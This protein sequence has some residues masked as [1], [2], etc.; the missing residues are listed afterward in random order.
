MLLLHLVAVAPWYLT[1]NFHPTTY[2]GIDPT[3]AQKAFVYAALDRDLNLMALADVEMDDLMAFVV[4][5]KSVLIAINSPLSLN[6]GLLKEKIK[7]AADGRRQIR[8]AEFRLAEH[9][10]RDCGI[11]VYGTPGNRS[12]CPAWMGAG[13]E[14]LRRIKEAGFDKYPHEKASQQFVETHPYAAYSVLLGSLP[15]PKPTLEGRLQRQLTLHDKGLR[16]KDPMDFFEEIT[17]HK[18]LK[19]IW[20]VELLYSPEQLDSLAAAYT[21]WC[22]VNKPEQTLSVGDES[23]GR[24]YLPEGTLKKHY[25]ADGK[26]IL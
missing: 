16:I 11:A 15:L 19:G 17:R 24:I 18:L 20:P 9:I 4:S 21:A 7:M 26:I 5:Q 23:E 12:A 6:R 13:F 25:M 1:M 3:S 22:V 8:G 2:I 14:L 10:L